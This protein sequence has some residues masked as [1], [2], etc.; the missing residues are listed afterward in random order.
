MKTVFTLLVGSLLGLSAMATDFRSSQLSITVQDRGNVRI[1][2][3]GRKMDADGNSIFM[4]DIEPGYHSIRVTKFKVNPLFGIFGMKNEVL[5]NSSVQVKPGT[6]VTLT[7]DRFG[8]SYIDEQKI[9]SNGRGKDDD[10]DYYDNDQGRDKGWKDKDGSNNNGYG[11]YN[12]YVNVIS[13]VEFQRVLD[14]VQ[15][16]WFE[17]NKVKS[18]VQI[19]QT[20][21]FT[22][23][24][25]KQMLQLFNFES[26][27]LDLAKQAYTKTVDKQNYQCVSDVFWFSSS[28]DELARFIRT[29]R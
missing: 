20:N 6:V 9:G 7:I 18:A 10:D 5:Y 11:A 17:N 25:V 24:Q 2:V 27:K 4:R 29:C 28:K 14:C 15:K 22:S 23:F 19:I 21:Y 16:E 13:D 3:D 12:G 26:N 1:M 8:K